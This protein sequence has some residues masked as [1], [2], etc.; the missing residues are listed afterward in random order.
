ME[1][2]RRAN[3]SPGFRS[4]SAVSMISSSSMFVLFVA[5]I[6]WFNLSLVPKIANG[7]KIHSITKIIKIAPI[8]SEPPP[9]IKSSAATVV[10]ARADAAPSASEAKIVASVSRRRT[11]FDVDLCVAILIILGNRFGQVR[12]SVSTR[13]RTASL[14]SGP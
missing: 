5:S 2:R 4:D 6:D 3:S 1:R 14:K 11:G 13:C 9:T 10:S 7:K 8:T 12:L